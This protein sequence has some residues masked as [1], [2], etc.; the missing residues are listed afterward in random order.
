MTNEAITE[1]VNKY[2]KKEWQ[3][4]PD[5]K[6]NVLY[7]DF[8]CRLEIDSSSIMYSLIREFKPT[9][10]LEVGSWYGWSTCVIMKA[11]IKNKLRASFICSEL[12]DELRI[13]TKANVKRKT[14]RTPRMIGDV[15]KNLDKLPKNLDF[16]FIDTNH[17]R[18]TAEWI[19][20]NIWPRLIQGGIFA[21][22]DWAVWEENGVLKGK[23]HNGTAGT[24][25]VEVLMGLIKNNQFPFEKIYW[26]YNNSAWDGM[27]P[28]CESGFWRKI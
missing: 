24:E 14:G 18:P 16:I 5:H 6:S 12:D 9:S 25:E 4:S 20:Q 23:G 1:L 27:S 28:T 21:M 2:F 7:D 13:K 26:S 10:C 22:H 17:D 15:T 8:E 11:L 3:L 19:A